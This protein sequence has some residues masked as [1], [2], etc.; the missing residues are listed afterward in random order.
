MGDLSICLY[1]Y[2]LIFKNDCVNVLLYETITV[3]LTGPKPEII[4]VTEYA[5]VL[6]DRMTLNN[7]YKSLEYLSFPKPWQT[8]AIVFKR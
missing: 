6:T 7:T 1:R 8:I 4:K 5:P 2:F 3:D